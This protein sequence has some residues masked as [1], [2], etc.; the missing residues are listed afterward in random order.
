MQ[1]KDRKDSRIRQLETDVAGCLGTEKG[2]QQ[3]AARES[4]EAVAVAGDQA[5]EF[6]EGDHQDGAADRGTQACDQ[7][8]GPEEDEDEAAAEQ[9]CRPMAAQR[10]Q[11]PG[12]QGVDQ[13]DVE[14]A[15]GEQMHGATLPIDHSQI[16]RQIAFV[17]NGQRPQNGQFLALRGQLAQPCRKG[18]FLEGCPLHQR[19]RPLQPG[20]PPQL[21]RPRS[22]KNKT[23]QQHRPAGPA[24]RTEGESTGKQ[25]INPRRERQ[26]V[27]QDIAGQKSQR[28]RHK[29]PTLPHPAQ[30]FCK[31]RLFFLN[32]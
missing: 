11:Q 29:F 6:I 17:A 30:I 22:E 3:G 5:G 21:H 10:P 20:H 2:Q 1:Q 9:P 4:R 27:A 32:L 19:R 13:T 26:K 14:A 8:I 31:V 18:F 28:T 24:E 15:Q 7:R 12:Q 25:Q 23:E 16:A